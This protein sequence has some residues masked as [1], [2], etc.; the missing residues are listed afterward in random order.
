MA[1]LSWNSL[2]LPKTR[3]D[4]FPGL[5]GLY[6]M[7]DVFLHNVI[8]AVS[9]EKAMDSAGI[10]DITDITN[11]D[12]NEFKADWQQWLPVFIGYIVCAAIG[13]LFFLLLPVTGCCCCCCCC[14]KKKQTKSPSHNRKMCCS[15]TLGLL[16]IVMASTASVV[17]VLDT[18]LQSELTVGGTVSTVNKSVATIEDYLDVVV[19]DVDT[20]L[21]DPFKRDHDKFFAELDAIPTEIIL[22]LE[23][24]TQ[25]C[26][27]HFIVNIKMCCHYDI[28]IGHI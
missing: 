22:T 24:K 14:C 6:S 23:E 7:I 28:L 2:N 13:I 5:N 21:I 11:I 19:E 16:V 20:K 1:N 17:L 4:Q 27:T 15:V 25:V 9:V 12:L 3:D 10:D 8:Q 26:A 18:V